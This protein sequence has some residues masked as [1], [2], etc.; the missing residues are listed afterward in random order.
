MASRSNRKTGQIQQQ[1][2]VSATCGKWF[3]KDCPT[4]LSHLP[5]TLLRVMRLS[6]A[7]FK[8][9]LRS[10]EDTEKM[11]STATNAWC[12]MNAEIVCFNCGLSTT[13]LGKGGIV[14]SFRCLLILASIVDTTGPFLHQWSCIY[15]YSQYLFLLASISICV[16]HRQLLC[17]DVYHSFVNDW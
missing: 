3:W 9:K 5:F 4:V 13:T 17:T 2:L 7:A 14:P 1:P 12:V 15:S 11:R 6:F 8:L 10:Y 16:C